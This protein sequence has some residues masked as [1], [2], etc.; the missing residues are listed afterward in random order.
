M[1]VLNIGTLTYLQTMDSVRCFQPLVR[2]N[3][4]QNLQPDLPAVVLTVCLQPVYNVE[5]RKKKH[6]NKNAKYLVCGNSTLINESESEW[7]SEIGE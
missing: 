4:V 7:K 6:E 5:R 2:E 3:V 1:I